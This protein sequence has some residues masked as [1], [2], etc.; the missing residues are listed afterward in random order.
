MPVKLK[1]SSNG[2]VTLDVPATASDFTLTVPAKTDTLA[3]LASPAFTGSPTIG[4]NAIIKAGD[5]GTVSQTMLASNIAGNGPAFGVYGSA[6]QTG[7]ASTAYTKVAFN[8][9]EFDTNSNF[10]STTNYR[11]TPTVAGYY[12][13][14]FSVYLTASN[15][16]AGQALIYKNGSA[17]RL[18]NSAVYTSS[19]MIV[20]GSSLIYLNGSTDYIEF[21]A[22]ASTSAGTYTIKASQGSTFAN[23]FLAR[24]A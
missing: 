1:S 21:Y 5:T 24:A 9:E 13:F 6:D 12:Q 16:A 18:P 23:G 2:S 8:T 15:L 17:F 14:N 4:G 10:D 3:T 7:L 20:G 19:G 22:Y 11:F